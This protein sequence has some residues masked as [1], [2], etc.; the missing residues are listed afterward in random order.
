MARVLTEK[1]NVKDVF[2]I[3]SSSLFIS[4]LRGGGVQ[5]ASIDE[6]SP[7]L[8]APKVLLLDHLS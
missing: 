6:P 4:A 2:T 8:A 7:P 1:S 3:H 5:E